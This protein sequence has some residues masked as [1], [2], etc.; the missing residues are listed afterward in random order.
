MTFI[1]CVLETMEKKGITAYKLCKD[2]G[3]SQQTFSNWKSGKMP[4]LDKA[5]AIIIYLGLSA[6]EIFGIVKKNIDL[7][8]EEQNLL[9]A[10][11]SA[12]PGIQEA[13]RKLLDMPE[14]ETNL[15]DYDIGK[16]AV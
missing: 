1:N 8:P 3:L 14:Q 13:T 6:D 2:I 10:Y 15:S 16:K 9:E 5:I 7:L 4:A 12:S 11:R